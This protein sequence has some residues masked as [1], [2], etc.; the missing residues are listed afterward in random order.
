MSEFLSMGGYAAYVWPS[1]GLTAVIM[2]VLLIASLR[3]LNSTEKTFKRLK[4][5]VGPNRAKPEE[6]PHGDEAKA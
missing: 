4:A 5:E 3:S 1:Y 2:L 6:T